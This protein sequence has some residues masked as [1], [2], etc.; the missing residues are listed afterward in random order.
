MDHL[1]LSVQTVRT[2][3]TVLIKVKAQ[4]FGNMLEKLSTDDR[5]KLVTFGKLSVNFRKL[6]LKSKSR[7]LHF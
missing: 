1:Y 2:V 4:D 6:S 3:Y 5:G 7:L